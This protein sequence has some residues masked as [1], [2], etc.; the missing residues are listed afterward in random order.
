M[1]KRLFEYEKYSDDWLHQRILEMVSRKK[2]ENWLEEL[3]D[4]VC[5]RMRD[6]LE[7]IW[8][9]DEWHY[10]KMTQESCTDE[11]NTDFRRDNGAVLVAKLDP[12][13]ERYRNILDNPR[14]IVENGA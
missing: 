3:Q 8:C 13:P 1:E 14:T 2:E 12:A 10:E 9:E 6:R 5:P 7:D 4:V 11:A